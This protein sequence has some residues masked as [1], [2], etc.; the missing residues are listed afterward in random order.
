MFSLFRND[1]YKLNKTLSQML[2]YFYNITKWIS[3][4]TLKLPLPGFILFT[5]PLRNDVLN[6]S[7]Y[8]EK[9]QKERQVVPKS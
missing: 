1:F 6:N 4:L 2:E 5:S 9:N 7:A 3:C 8:Q